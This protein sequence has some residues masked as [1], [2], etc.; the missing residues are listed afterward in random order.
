MTISVRIKFDDANLQ[1]L[2]K[3]LPGNLRESINEANH[4]TALLTV[5]ELKRN[6]LADSLVSARRKSAGQKIRAKKRVNSSVVTMPDSLVKLDTMKPHY[7]AVRFGSSI[8]RWA[9]SI[10][11]PQHRTGKSRIYRTRT[12]RIAYSEGRKSAMYVMPHKFIDKSLLKI[13]NRFKNELRK[14][15]KKGFSNSKR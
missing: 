3:K 6:L 12:G 7:V 2:L 1:Y 4:Q 14:G 10:P 13:R 9:N 5:K 15:V 8:R 11:N